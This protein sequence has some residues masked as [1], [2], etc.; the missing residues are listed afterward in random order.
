MEQNQPQPP[1]FNPQQQPQQPA[2]QYQPRVSASPMMDPV[3]AV[4]TCFAK[5]F[6]FK[7]RARRSEFWWF[8][9]FVVIVSSVLSFFG[10]LT[11]IVGYLSLA[12]SLA[13]LIPE[14]AALCRRLHDTGRGSWW[15]A[16]MALLI[17]GYYGSFATLIGN[18]FTELATATNPQDV[19]GMAQEMAN[20]I[21]ESPGLA[22]VMMICSMGSILLALIMLIFT[23]K[24]SDWGENKYGPSPKYK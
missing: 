18:N 12:F 17:A 14:L 19:M 23:I 4:K 1:V 9:L 6:D 22:T 11:P 3:T 20:S 13:V 8:A 10:M 5:Y 2:P 7:G 24:D 15:V 21:Q 16:L